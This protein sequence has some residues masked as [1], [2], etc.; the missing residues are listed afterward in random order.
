[1][2]GGGKP[3]LTVK[4]AVL[5]LKNSQGKKSHVNRVGGEQTNWQAKRPTEESG[6]NV[7]VRRGGGGWQKKEKTKT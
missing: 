4:F 3:K 6:G 1:M 2:I 7:R 5:C